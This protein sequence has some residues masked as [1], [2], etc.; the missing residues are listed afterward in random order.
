LDE[1]IETFSFGGRTILARHP[2]EDL[3]E[4]QR[5]NTAGEDES[6]D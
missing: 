3:K 4:T 6:E 5:P 1:L 2:L